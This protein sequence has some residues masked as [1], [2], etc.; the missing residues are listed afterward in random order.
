MVTCF[1]QKGKHFCNVLH[2]IRS[3]CFVRFFFLNKQ[4]SDSFNCYTFIHLHLQKSSQKYKNPRKNIAGI[5]HYRASE[6]VC[7]SP[8][9]VLQS[10]IY[11][12]NIKC[13]GISLSE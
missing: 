12:K 10:S 13:D 4:D 7:S 3:T 1:C 2:S 11:L 9:L 8:V 5:P 6:H